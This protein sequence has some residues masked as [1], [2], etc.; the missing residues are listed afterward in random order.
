MR[1]E[2]RKLVGRGSKSRT[3]QMVVSTERSPEAKAGGL[4]KI[5]GGR[6]ASRFA[7]ILASWPGRN[8]IA[9]A[10]TLWLRLRVELGETEYGDGEDS[11]DGNGDNEGLRPRGLVA[12]FG[13]QWL[14]L[15]GFKYPRGIGSEANALERAAIRAAI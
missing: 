7:R 12:C 1:G 14:S 8:A 11:G 4:K 2:N 15:G 5:V 10:A 3:S 13:F 9:A 6:R